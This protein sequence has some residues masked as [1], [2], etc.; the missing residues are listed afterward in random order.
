MASRRVNDH[1]MT[2]EQG[3]LGRCPTCQDTF[4]EDTSAS[5]VILG[6]AVP[7]RGRDSVPEC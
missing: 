1:Q 5:L 2:P 3:M 6:D 4:L 7:V